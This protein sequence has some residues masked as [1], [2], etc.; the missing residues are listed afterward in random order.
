MGMIGVDLIGKIRRAFFEQR[1]PIKEIA[2]LCG[3]PNERNFMTMFRRQVGQTAKTFRYARVN[4]LGNARK[5]PR[6]LRRPRQTP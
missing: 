6:S 1:R 5:M 3:Y 2:A 4:G